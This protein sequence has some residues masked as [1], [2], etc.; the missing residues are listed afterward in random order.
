MP[1]MRASAIG[2][3][4]ARVW[5]LNPI[6]RFSMNIGL[7]SGATAQMSESTPV[8]QA[9]TGAASSCG[10]QEANL[11]H[12]PSI[13]SNGKYLPKAV[14]GG[15]DESESMYDALISFTWKEIKRP[16]R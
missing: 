14:Q 7:R 5:A 13:V 8:V 12:I 11:A 1:I 9:F 2:R 4:R 16:H 10:A 6:D 15:W 3:R